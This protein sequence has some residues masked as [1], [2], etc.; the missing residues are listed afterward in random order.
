MC[1]VKKIC[2]VRFF[3]SRMGRL[4]NSF[5]WGI[6]FASATWSVAL[7]LYWLLNMNGKS[8][9]ITYKLFGFKLTYEFQ[10]SVDIF[11]LYFH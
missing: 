3:N 11:V 10:K 2:F 1:V 9:F 4:N 5:L 8:Y 7:Y 6:L